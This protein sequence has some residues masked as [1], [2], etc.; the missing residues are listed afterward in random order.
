MGDE[1]IAVNFGRSGDPRYGGG[2]VV[3]IL[4]VPAPLVEGFLGGPDAS[5]SERADQF[6]LCDIAKPGGAAMDRRHIGN[7]SRAAVSG[8]TASSCS[9]F[10]RT[11][12]VLET[13]LSSWVTVTMML[14]EPT[15]RPT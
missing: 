12:Y 9:R 14:L 11:T 4:K 6:C 8:I 7:A 5:K 15:L 10:T 1:P 3:G 2:F 13:P